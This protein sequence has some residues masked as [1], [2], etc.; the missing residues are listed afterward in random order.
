VNI[1]SANVSVID[2]ATNTV[3]DTLAVGSFP[4][5]VA[6]TRRRLIVTNTNDAGPG[7]LR[8]VILDARDS[9]PSVITFDPAVFPVASPGTISLLSRL[10]VL[11]TLEI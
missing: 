3:V 5:E 11:A 1:G 10:P 7:S 2:I 9:V 4:R 6:T 8:Q